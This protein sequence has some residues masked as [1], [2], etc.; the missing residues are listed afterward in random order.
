MA[1]SQ[2]SSENG[3][4]KPCLIILYTIAPETSTPAC[5]RLQN[6]PKEVLTGRPKSEDLPQWQVKV[7]GPITGVME[8][9][10][11]DGVVNAAR[12]LLYKGWK[13]CW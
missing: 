4:S 1:S 11:A 13:D 8:G 9:F 3:R 2:F 5:M 7:T 10:L 12:G 6:I